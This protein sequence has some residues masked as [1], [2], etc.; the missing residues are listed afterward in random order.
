V[1][2]EHSVSIGRPA[3]VVFA[4]IVDGTRN[5]QWRPAVVETWLRSGDGGVG[6]V[7]RQVMRGP[8]ERLA[9]ADYR[10]T[11]YEPNSSYGIE[12][13]AGPVRGTAVYSL[14]PGDGADTTLTLEVVLKPRG[15]M[16]VVSGFVL[17]Q[18]VDE[19]DSLDRLRAILTGSPP[20][21]T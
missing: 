5:P 11:R 13:I 4:A 12:V 3:A 1:R 14:A 9:D 19:M 17:R 8:A 2:G 10:V 20:P 15:L 21:T 7:W 18:L 6:S 16:R